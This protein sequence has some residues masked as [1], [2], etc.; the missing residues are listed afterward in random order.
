MRKKVQGFSALTTGYG[1]GILLGIYD[2]VGNYADFAISLVD[3]NRDFLHYIS[4]FLFTYGF[5]RI[6]LTARTEGRY[7]AV[8][9]GVL[10]GLLVADMLLEWGLGQHFGIAVV[11]CLLV[12]LLWGQE[13]HVWIPT[14]F[15]ALFFTAYYLGVYNVVD[16][17]AQFTDLI[18]AIA[19]I[20]AVVAISA[21][22][23]Y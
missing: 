2:F 12:Y 16:L 5:F 3:D 22:D 8:L 6:G 23:E 21:V 4:L 7:A 18:Y 1:I 10:N 17:L 9:A 20:S 11:L 13:K 14:A 19:A 15:T